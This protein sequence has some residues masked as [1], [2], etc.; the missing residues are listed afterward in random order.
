MRNINLFTKFIYEGNFEDD[1]ISDLQLSL[2]LTDKK[3][4]RESFKYINYLITNFENND[5]FVKLINN[6]IDLIDLM[7]E[8]I[9]FNEDEV[10]VNRKRIKRARESILAY[11]NKY[12]NSDLLHSA[13]KLDEIIL[14]KN[15]N[16]DDLIILLKSLIDKKEDVNIIKKILNTNKGIIV[17]NQNVIFDYVFYKAIESIIDNNCDIYYYIALLKIFYS[18]KID[19]KKYITLLNE[20]TDN[21]EFSNEIYSIILGIKRSLSPNEIINKYGILTN[22]NSTY[23]IIPNKITSN[24]KIITI[25]SN[26]TKLRDDALSIKE[27]G[28]KYIVGIHIADPSKYIDPYSEIDIQAKNNFKNIYIPNA[29]IRL[30]PNDLENLFTLDENKI[31]SVF[32]LYCILDKYG[33]LEDYIFKENEIS[34]LNNLSY[35][36]CDSLIDDR[37]KNEISHDLNNL[38]HLASALENK[39]KKKKEYWYKKETDS[40]DKQIKFHKSDK[41][42]SE[43]MVLYGNIIAKI[44]CDNSIPYTYRTQDN[45]YL[46]NLIKKLNIKLDETTK[47]TI[48]NIYLT[49]KY[50]SIPLF[51]HGLN[52]PIYSHSSDSLR[53][54]PDLYNQYLLHLFYFKDK[55]FEFDYNEHLDLINYFNERS[56]ELS[57]FKGEYI[58][59]LKLEKKI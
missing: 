48:N 42:I 51:H 56:T 38:Y 4:I 57:L 40:I 50:S 33:N 16:I 37:Y 12:K 59:A 1:K 46:D 35:N 36:E 43:L 17:L 21:N 13:N 49:S 32:S 34:V 3:L 15:I 8:E 44:A 52:L 9:E 29:S 31:R 18:S 24:E 45:S 41:I 53:R 10:I 26:N 2:N 20:Y 39:N 25:D 28:N 6:T 22:L 23:V 47:K 30:F 5:Y 11:S 54:Y 19:K 14:D 27:D 55:N 58:R 7:C